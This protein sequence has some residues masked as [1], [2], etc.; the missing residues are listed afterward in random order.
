MKTLCPLE[1]KS[2]YIKISSLKSISCMKYLYF[3]QAK[4]LLRKLLLKSLS[5][6]HVEQRDKKYPYSKSAHHEHNK[7]HE[8]NRDKLQP[9]L[10]F[11]FSFLQ[12]SNFKKRKSNNENRAS[13]NEHT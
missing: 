13:N 6:K 1:N 12:S 2:S 3:R 9:R 10:I 8:K 7:V 5:M 4:R 11:I